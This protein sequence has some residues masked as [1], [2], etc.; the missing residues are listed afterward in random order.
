MLGAGVVAAIPTFWTLPPKILTG[1]GAAG[2]IALINTLGQVGGIVSP[3]MV[4][5]VKDCD[6]QHDAGALCH[7][8]LVRALCVAAADGASARPESQGRGGTPGRI[9]RGIGA[10]W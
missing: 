9:G 8:R 6:R 7:R 3:V 1:A 2:G 5:S 10:P 4:G